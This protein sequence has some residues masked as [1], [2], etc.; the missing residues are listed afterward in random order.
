MFMPPT[1]ARRN[2][3][4]TE[5]MA[6]YRSTLTPAWPSTS[7]AMRPAGPPP[8]MATRK[9]EAGWGMAATGQAS[10]AG[11]IA[12]DGCSAESVALP[13]RVGADMQGRVAPREQC[14]VLVVA[15]A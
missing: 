7:A 9:E 8:M 3:R 6:S 4:P 2:L 10:R 5:G 11:I 15:T 13:G 14:A 12:A 1:P